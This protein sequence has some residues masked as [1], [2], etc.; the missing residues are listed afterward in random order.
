MFYNYNFKSFLWQ[1]SSSI[2]KHKKGKPTL[3]GFSL[4]VMMTL[5]AVTGIKA[6]TTIINP[7]TDGGFNLGNTFTANG[8][9]VANQGVSPVKWALGTA[10]SGTTSV[11][12]TTNASTSV[13]LTAANANIAV[14]QIVYGLGI[15]ANTYV[16]AISG[17][18]LTLS[19]AATNTATGVTLGFG[20]YAGGISVGT[21]Q[22][23]NTSIA[24][25]T[26]SV[27]LS[28]ANPN[29]SV[30][31][32]IAPIAGFIAADTYV[33]SINGTTLGLSKASLNSTVL[34]VAQT[35]TFT[36]T[37]SSISGNAAYVTNDNGITNS[38]GG[39]PTN[40]TV[41]F[42]KDITTVPA[43]ET[44]MTLTFDVKSVPSSGGGWQVWV[45]PTSQTVTGTDTQVTAPFTYGVSWPGAT[46]ISFNSG[47][48]VATTRTTA[49]IPKSFAGTSFRLIFVWTNGTS[50]GTLAPAA[51][52]NISLVS[53][54]PQ[55]IT[56]AHSGL[57]SQPGTWDGASVPT[58][59]DTVV[60]DNDN[61]T[62]NVDSRYSGAQD[63]IMA[64]ANTLV[65]FALSSVV[66]DF[67]IAN[68]LNIA[69]SGA[70]FNVHDGTNGKYLKLGHNLDVGA[71]ARFD[72]NI[73]STS[74]F[75]GRLTLNG[76]DVQTVTV[77]P[78]GF[79]GGSAAGTNA[80]ANVANVL[81]QLEVTNTSTASPN[82]IWNANGVRIKSNLVLTS[83]RMSIASGK[84]LILGNFSA[85]NNIT[86]PLGFGITDGTISRWT[87]GAAGSNSYINVGTEYPNTDNSFKSYWYPFVSATK[88]NRA[89]YLF[90]D[91]APSVAGEVAVTYT[92][93]TATTTGL[94]VADGS[95]TINNR[96]GANWSFSTPDSNAIPA[97]AAV[98]YTNAAGTHRVAV[99]VP[100]AYEAKDGSSRL[101]NLSAAMPGTH[102]DGTAMPFAV[103][104]GLT[105]ANLTAGAI[106]VGIGD[107]SKL[108]TTTAITSQTSGSWDATSTWVGG[109]VPSCSD[110]VIIA[111]GHTVTVTAAA[112]AAAV[113]INAGGTLVNNGGSSTMTVGCTNNNAAFYNYG[114]YTMTTGTLK[115]NGFMSHKL[116]STFN[117][118]GGDIVID[119][120]N[121]GDA[122][123]SVAFGG[124]SC[125]IETSNL[126][127][128]G[129]KITIVDP[130]VNIATPVASV[131]T[132]GNFSLN[133]SGATGT[134]SK[135]ISS[136]ITTNSFTVASDNL[137]FVGQAVSGTN[138]PAG[139]TVSAV[140]V[141]F[142]G[143][144]PPVTITLSQNV[145]ATVASGTSL[146]FSSM[147]NGASSVI[148]EA[149]AANANLAVGQGIS[150]PGIQAG[151]TITGII[152]GQTLNN[153]VDLVKL[154]LSLPVSGLSTSPI[155]SQ[156][157]LTIAGVSAGSSVAILPTA[158]AAIQI[159]MIVSGTGIAP[160]TFLADYS[161]TKMTFSEPIQAGAPSPLVLSFAP[162]NTQFSG[163][164]IYN[165]PNHYA[166]GL[167]HTLQ[168]GD[169]VST[170]NTSLITNGFNC[171]FQAG[172]G[173]MSIGNLTVDAPN[174]AERFMNVSSNNLNAGTVPAGYNI[175]IQ[176]ALTITAGSVFKKTFANAPVYVGGN[177][178]NNGS[179]LMPIGQTLYL[180]NIINGALTPTSLPQTISGTGTYLANQ[181]SL[182]GSSTY[183]GFSVGSFTVNNNSAE[184]VTIG[185]PNF[186]TNSVSLASGIVHTTATNTI[187]CGA[188]DVMN[189]TYS[190]G[191]FSFAT[192]VVGSA[193]CYIDGP[194]AH[195]NKFDANNT[196]NRLFPTGKNGKYLPISIASTGGVELMVEAFDSNSGTVN[197]TNA[198]NLSAA[199]WKVTRVGSLGGFTGY[200]VRLGSLTSP[201]TAS[202]VIVQSAT[203][204]GTYD[205]VSTPTSAITYDAAHFSLPN[206]PTI[207]LTTA[208]TGGLLGNFAY[209]S[210]PGCSGTPAPG[211]TIASSSTLCSGQSV[212]LSLTNA[213][214]GAG[215]TYQWQSSTNG[216]SSWTSISGATAA[217]Y[218]AT[219]S[220]NTS[221]QCLVTCSSSTGT[222]TPVAVSVT[223]S[224]ATTTGA[225]IC[226]SGVANLSASG[227]SI[228]NWYDAA[229]GGNLVTTGTTYSPTLSATTTYY[230]ASA[231][232]TS[233]SVNTG[234]WAGT[235]ASSALF[236]GV[237]FDAT[238]KIVL[239]TVTVYPKNT[240]ARTPITIALYDA[241][242]NVVAGTTPVTF[243]P[244]LNTGTIGSISQVIT[245]NY[246][247]PAGTGYR[248]VPTYGLIAT[249]N[250]LGNS[251]ATITYPTAGAL[252]LTGNVSALTDAIVT[253]ANTTNCFHNLTFDEICESATR[254]AVTATVG[255]SINT[256][257]INACGSYTWSNTG[258]TYTTS[259][260]Y[261]GT[262]TNCIT[263][264]LDLTITPITSNTTTVSACG[265]YTWSV[266]SQ[267]YTTSGTYSV[268]SGC[269]TEVLNL[270]INAAA[271]T[272]QPAASIICS[273]VGA[274][275]SFAVESNI[276]GASYTWEYRVVTTANP[277]PAWITITAANAGAVYSNYTTATLGVT[278][279]ATLPAVGTQ[280][281]VTVTGDCGVLTS[282]SAAITV[283]S[284]VKAGTISAPATSVC[285]GSDITLTLTGYAGTSFQW[286]SAPMSTT[287]APGVFTDILGATGTTYT[288][289]GAAADMDKSYRVIVTNSCGNTTATTA[290]KTLKVDP[291]SVAG[292]V[293]GGGKVCSGS[294]GSVKVAGY[295]GKI[296]WQYSTDGVTYVNAPAAAAAQTN[297]FGTTSTS[298]TAATYLLTG[299]TADVYFRAKLTSGTCS[300]AYTTPVQYTI[301]T[302]AL[303]GTISAASTLL[304][305]ASGTTLTLTS[306]TG[307]ITWEKATNLTTPTW[308]AVPN[309]NVLSISTGNLTVST[310][311]RAKVTIGSCST[312][313]SNTVVVAVVA[314]PVAKTLVT[315]TTSPT[316]AT[317]LTAICTNSTTPKTLTVGAGY[318]G[319]IEWQV[320]TT[321]ATAGFTT[322][323]GETGATYTIT[324]PAVG[325]NYYRVRMYNTC[326]T[327]VFGTAKAVYYQ[328]CG[329]PAKGVIAAPFGVVAYPNPYTDNF[330][331]SLTTSSDAAVRVAI[332]DMTGKLIDKRE[333]APTEVSGL[334]VGDRYPSGV[335]NVVV[336]Q[337][338]DVQTLRVVKK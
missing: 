302:E 50:A 14:G 295:V 338:S 26:Y 322:I 279:T 217:T 325:A 53:R 110:N 336:T 280:Y 125:K 78:A 310:Q 287:A 109:V 231:S 142:V 214:A 44:A 90:P 331:L 245:L 208:Q 228:L 77:D 153:T 83:A 324:N 167:N 68:D 326:G 241:T 122:A 175:N 168:I 30:G 119:S 195:A 251:T 100:G 19:Q 17:T 174:G 274:T 317:A 38:Y 95:Y 181:W 92:N 313:S 127:L 136:S 46:L 131:T 145:S 97:G 261:T 139:T 328:D 223:Q 59:V 210:G 248:L 1:L 240:A 149:V 189:A 79:V 293:T 278:K 244:T 292:T 300:S 192:N 162:F 96:Y 143:F 108:D 49:F 239:K 234:A 52:D 121:N 94:T 188:P 255:S 218:S 7:A 220:V 156:Q 34:A 165:S 227:S 212:A 87:S 159:G 226:S 253:T 69:G 289:T 201:V 20:V 155:T 88:M 138:I 235:A 309:S 154:N 84:R 200:N 39:Y 236:K 51:I 75:V 141:G 23:T 47:A 35:M 190:S 305:P 169:G 123:T 178:V 66:D 306:A 333:V 330:N 160:G 61:E 314:K 258:Q 298:S 173:L 335:Y 247:I 40:R 9:T 21:T 2:E 320:S 290:T 238:N 113:T 80:F 203:E 157:A 219:P 15:S 222:S 73:G 171:Q 60:L 176:N 6:Q 268:V 54:M 275:A 140:S 256:T 254:T 163:S 45:A 29:I 32:A 81:N 58:P 237:A 329:A 27:T 24:I 264:K 166:T 184:G 191:T 129:G 294:N 207:A 124:T 98:V 205:I 158:N 64:G 229:T 276:T 197:P 56:C 82:V 151:T 299:I 170:Q 10:A 291:I 11:G 104:N 186:R 148:L 334:Q 263:E 332:Y 28:A 308:T 304:C 323:A 147:Q 321:S 114:T 3:S 5:F 41:Y 316:G 303:V 128:T 216:G 211:A 72:C 265:S 71:G 246:T 70:R 172:G 76:N 116:N 260:I 112:N 13:T 63:V 74:A 25:N 249:T 187:Y 99:H 120:N 8:W 16:Q 267:T 134:F 224:T 243:I 164:F 161:G 283:L 206:L 242:G 311:Y 307:V 270:T 137:Y 221:Y 4:V 194:I 111:S 215:V 250:T 91:T 273:T 12:A 281:R 115:V 118:T 282:N 185:I 144:P 31:M 62:V 225:I 67:T 150:G 22:T 85:L 89:L 337:G 18:T 319:L 288:I 55:E 230:V 271:I 262:T 252:K 177:V 257:T 296:Q 198:S 146:N 179:L 259:G 132:V 183:P 130:L 126:A 233:S 103:R 209:A 57:W 182:T 327:E 312:V 36:A 315:N 86:C 65:N 133:T 48:Q 106:Y 117:Q 232:A 266:N 101:M 93:S 269:H 204:N 272:A 202:S 107:G 43:S 152:T 213:T 193:T 284:T 285:L 102:Q 135:A 37:S 297:P 33:A 199:R 196:Q 180:G 301:G 42:Y 105:L 286:Q 318:V 277:S